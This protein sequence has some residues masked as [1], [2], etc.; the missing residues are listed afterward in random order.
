MKK[1]GLHGYV[2]EF[3]VDYNIIGISDIINI[4]KYF[5]KKHDI[6]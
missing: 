2:F 1:T 6:K 3:P 4:D 5:M